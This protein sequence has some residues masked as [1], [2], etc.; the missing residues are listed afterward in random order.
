MDADWAC[1]AAY[2]YVLHLEPGLR[3]WEYLRRNPRYVSDWMHYRRSPSQRIAARWGL[4]SLANPRLDAREVSPVWAAGELAPI[5]IVR[6]EMLHAQT[7]LDGARRFS[8][9]RLTGRKA[10]LHDGSGLRLVVRL[11]SQEVQLRLGDRLSAGDRFAYQVPAAGD[12]RAAWAALNAFRALTPT[13]GNG[14]KASRE[15]PDR[16]DIF[17]VRALQV[18]DGLAAGASQRELAVAIFGS[19][20][21]A[22]GWQ[23]DGA[24]RAQV[25][26][27]IRRARALMVREYRSLIGAGS[28]ASPSRRKRKGTQIR[29]PTGAA[30]NGGSVRRPTART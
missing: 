23:P 11:F 16:T 6:D 24:L 27:L 19:D 21:V 17:H 20:A 5:A 15:R 1:S 8:L 18:L 22:R 29:R 25:R 26:Y 12:D 13:S 14:S 28:S 2:V 4:A 3:A 9:W 10:L 7:D 30:V